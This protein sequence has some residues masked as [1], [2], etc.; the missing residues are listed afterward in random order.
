SG[1][2]VTVTNAS[3]NGS[4]A[5]GGSTQIGANFNYSGTNTTPTTFAINGTT[6][7]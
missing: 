6:C 5:T 4:L 2:N 1:K 7:G 3:W